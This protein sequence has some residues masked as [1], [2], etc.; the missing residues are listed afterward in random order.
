M[1]AGYYLGPT[2]RDHG[3]WLTLPWPGDPTLPWGHPERVELLPP[4]L[5]PGLVSWSQK[6]LVHPLSGAP[7]RYTVGQK[8]FMHLWFAFDPITG[9][10]LYRSG[11]KR[12]AKGVGKDPF[13][14]A[15][16]LCELCGPV[17]LHDFDGTR[18]VGRRRRRSLVQIGANSQDQAKKVLAVANAMISPRMKV[19]YSV[20]DG[21]TR[22]A[23]G[24]GSR[25]ELLKASV[26]SSEGDPPTALFLNESHHM[27]K[28]NGG[29]G[30]AEVARRNVGKSPE[31]VYARLLE[32]T[33]AH[34]QGA[35]SVAEQS[36]VAWQDQVTDP[37]KKVDILY[38]SREAPPNLAV[39][40]DEQ[41]ERA[42]R[43]A[44]SDAEWADIERLRS[45]AQDGRTQES[46]A[47]RFYFNGLAAA[48]DSWIV[49][50]NFAALTRASTVVESGD[51]IAMFLDCS[52]SGDATALSACRLSDG[53]VFSLGYW[54]PKRGEVVEKFLAP[55]EEVDA[56]AREALETYR[57][58]WFGIDPSPAEDDD[59]ET[60]Y[61]MPTID[62]LHRDYHKKLKLWATPGAKG[63]SVLFD[64]RLSTPGARDRNRLFTEMAMQTAL[65]IDGP[66]DG[67]PPA[68]PVF[69]HDGDPFLMR[70]V[71]NAK[72]RPNQWGVSLGKVNRSSRKLVDY[73]VTMV[74]ARMGARIALNSPKVR[75]GGQGKGK[76]TVFS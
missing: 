60:L 35:D 11:V 40:D 6:W 17:Q 33:N 39:W 34:H 54:A 13:A 42:L 59:T 36:Y 9:R 41:C 75:I 12:G 69:T 23:L 57:V 47:I 71:Y 68:E 3:A 2:E 21:I 20:D 55:R 64:M 67:E 26:K 7:W 50:K 28:S 29:H 38:D 61:W 24:S 27:L 52:K 10:W 16:S 73:A 65:D 51:Q 44:Y 4:S 30:I 48:E 45:E 62:G 15:L 58:V 25:I 18:V 14:A 5:G 53:H 22:T 31:D 46:D 8:R 56:A 72:R 49:P 19:A 37:E 66:P 43:A 63:H 70:N 1:P 76:V 32:L 74:G